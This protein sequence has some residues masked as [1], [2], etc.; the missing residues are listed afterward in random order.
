[1]GLLFYSLFVED[2]NLTLISVGLLALAILASVFQWTLARKARCPLCITPVME[3]KRCSKHRNAKTFLGSYRLRVALSIIF[4]GSFLCPFCH[5][6]TAME[7][8]PKR[9]KYSR[10]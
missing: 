3:S 9:A 7:A 5:E 8:R 6:P 4:K 10:D 1:M 2:K